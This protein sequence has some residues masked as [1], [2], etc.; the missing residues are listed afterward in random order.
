MD[1]ASI[2]WIILGVIAVWLLGHL[3][4]RYPPGASL[5]QWGG[6]ALPGL[7]GVGWF[8]FDE[9]MLFAKLSAVGD[10]D[11]AGKHLAP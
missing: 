5:P 4:V 2:L 3:H 1:P 8:M 11:A 10:S 7:P 6:V 9:R